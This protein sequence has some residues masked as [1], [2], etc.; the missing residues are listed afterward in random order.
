MDVRELVPIGKS[1]IPCGNVRYP[2]VARPRPRAWCKDDSSG[3]SQVVF[4]QPEPVD[5]RKSGPWVPVGEEIMNASR[6]RPIEV[7]GPGDS[8][9]PV[10]RLRRVIPP[11]IARDP[12]R[13][14]G[15]SASLLG[16]RTPRKPS[17]SLPGRRCRST[18]QA[19][20]RSSRGSMG[21]RPQTEGVD[22]WTPPEAMFPTRVRDFP[23]RPR[24]NTAV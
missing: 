14:L 15:F 17:F 7:P 10:S 21:D 12:N 6:R 16:T 19:A 22:R 8:T 23:S 1:K 13:L 24:R 11:E 5:A 3:I 4:R 9:P 2:L 18:S 20:R